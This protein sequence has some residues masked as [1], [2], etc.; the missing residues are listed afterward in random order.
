MARGIGGKL[1]SDNSIVIVCEGTETEF[2]YF[3]ELCKFTNLSWRIVPVPSE[4]V[5]AK[6]K[7][8]RQS[9]MRTLQDGDSS[10]FTGPEYYVGLAEVD[11]AT[12]EQF[13]SEPT[14]WVRAAQLY[15]ERE[16]YYEAWAVYDLDQGRDAAHPEARALAE[17]V[18]DLHI[19]FSA[20]SFEEWL[21]LHFER[22]PKEYSHSE[23][24]SE[25]DIKCGHKD[26]EAEWNCH[27]ETC[28]GG[29]LR[30]CKYIPEY[31]KKD[32][33]KMVAITREK[34]HVA[35]VNAAWSRSLSADE[36][37]KCNPYTDVDKLV[38][39]LL[40]DEYDIKWLHSGDVFVHDDR[41]YRIDIVD[42]TVKITMQSFGKTGL[43]SADKIFWCD[44]EYNM[45]Q[46]ACPKMNFVFPEVNSE[47]T[48]CNKPT[49]K[50]V[51]C[52]ND[53]KSSVKRE[54]YIEC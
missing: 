49:G 34:L 47:V 30:E 22:N 42:G 37:Y 2:P 35:Y 25:E 44:G 51:L 28:I 9:V 10:E 48:L 32:G 53:N 20:Y 3:Q 33:A 1:L 38:M 5:N 19:A 36:A 45:M 54:Y 12:Y 15:K 39:R 24:K 29:R 6:A 8:A 26:C 31:E 41:E 4:R 16:G 46:S 27:G 23:C 18:N 43:I 13:K 17:R 21:L 52:I 11:Q 50:A 40:Q 7:A 14:R